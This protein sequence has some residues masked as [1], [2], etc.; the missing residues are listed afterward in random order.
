M[1]EFDEATLDSMERDH[2]GFQESVRDFEEATLPLCSLCGSEDTAQVRCGVVQRSINLAAVTTKL[3]LIPNGPG[4]GKYF[5]N[6]CK[7]FFD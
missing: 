5:C 7:K 6:A 3:K 4:P 2:P 1:L